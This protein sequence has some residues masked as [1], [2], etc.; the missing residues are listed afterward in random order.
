VNGLPVIAVPGAQVLGTG[1]PA[2]LPGVSLS[3]T[4]NTIGETFTVTLSDTSGLLSTTGAAGT[5]TGASSTSLTISGTLAQ[6]NTDL[7][8]LHDTDGTAGSDPITLNASD[9]FGNAAT[10]QQI[11]VTVNGLPVIAVP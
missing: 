3:E 8:G 4:G 9:S 2:A 1:K 10:Q 7:A 11:A 6:V 5:I